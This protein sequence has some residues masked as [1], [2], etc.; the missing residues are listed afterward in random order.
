MDLRK[1]GRLHRCH[2]GRMVPWVAGPFALPY[3]SLGLWLP[4]P[5]LYLGGKL[6]L[7][8]G[9]VTQHPSPQPKYSMAKRQEGCPPIRV[10]LS[11]NLPS[12]PSQGDSE[13]TPVVYWRWEETLPSL[14]VPWVTLGTCHPFLTQ[15]IPTERP[16]L[17]WESRR[18]L[19]RRGKFGL[20]SWSLS[21]SLSPSSSSPPPLPLSASLPLPP[22]V[23]LL[24][25]L[26]SSAWHLPSL[27]T[28]S[29]P[30]SL[31]CIPW[32]SLCSASLSLVPACRSV[33]IS[34]N[35]SLC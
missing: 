24:S 16:Q 23:F 2:C 6:T 5:K 18:G 34:T 9:G 25:E 30:S 35:M 26:F 22:L 19:E 10:F 1:K 13:P 3:P 33:S 4:Y 21:P 27:H 8:F 31:L 20:F 17:L 7:A 14:G 12:H 15:P 28:S 11:T 32:W 29:A